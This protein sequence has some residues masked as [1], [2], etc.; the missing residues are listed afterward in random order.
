MLADRNVPLAA[1]V[2]RNPPRDRASTGIVGLSR[3]PAEQRSNGRASEAVRAQLTEA[4]M[5]GVLGAGAHLNAENLARQL[6]VSHIP[7]REALRCLDAEGWVTVRPH[8]GVFVRM[9][10]EQ[11]LADLFE[12]RMMIEGHTT[13]CGAQRRSAADLDALEDILARQRVCH[14]GL[15]LAQINAEFHV[16]AARCSQNQTLVNFVCTLN[17]RIRFYFSTVAPSR[18]QDS[19]HEHTVLVD[20]LRRRDVAQA[21]IIVEQHMTATRF[22][23]LDALRDGH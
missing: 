15:E 9:R 8:Q 1:A 14:D 16:A 5:S 4:I 17:M 7:V 20:A 23:V 12:A 6:G 21:G 19:L 18:R 10:S 3:L 22:A 13:R 11:E 2:D